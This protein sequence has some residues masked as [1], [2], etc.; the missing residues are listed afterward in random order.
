MVP[1]FLIYMLKDHEKFIPSIAKLFNGDR[2]VFVVNLLKDLKPYFAII[3]PR[4]S[5]CQHL[6]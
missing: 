4:T 1:F 5:N 2:K 3:Y 6:F